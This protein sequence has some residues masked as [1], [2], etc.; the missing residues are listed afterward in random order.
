M[1]GG[2]NAGRIGREGLAVSAQ[3]LMDRSV[4]VL[5]GE[6]PEGD[7]D[8]R[9]ADLSLL[10]HRLLDPGVEVLSFE[11]VLPNEKLGD[12][13]GPGV[14]DRPAPHVLSRYVDVREDRDGVR[15]VSD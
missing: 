7:V 6:V 4:V 3:K 8:G 1:L 2:V 9:D 11:R 10:P 14:L 15:G 5:A 12:D 13:A